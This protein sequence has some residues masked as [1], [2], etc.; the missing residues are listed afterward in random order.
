MMLCAFCSKPLPPVTAGAIDAI[1]VW[2]QSGCDSTIRVSVRCPHCDKVIYRKDII[3]PYS[4]ELLLDLANR[5]GFDVETI[6]D[7]SRFGGGVEVEEVDYDA[8]VAPPGEPEP[9][10]AKITLAEDAGELR[11]R[12]WDVTYRL[13]PEDEDATFSG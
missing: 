11:L 8:W 1:G 10:W 4:Y 12:V 3:F 7:N 13:T 5:H 6:A 2:C 9:D